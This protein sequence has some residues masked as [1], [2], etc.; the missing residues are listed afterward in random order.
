MVS[1]SDLGD[2][3]S[4][5]CRTGGSLEPLISCTLK[6]SRDYGYIP[7]NFAEIKTAGAAA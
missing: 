2:L 6:D 3:I 7:Q 5:L 1:D 4:R